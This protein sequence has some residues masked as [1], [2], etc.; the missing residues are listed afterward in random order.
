MATKKDLVEAYSFSRRRL[1]TAFVSGAPGGRE[2]EPARPGRTVVGG[3][4]LAVLLIAGAAIAGIFSPSIPE[5]WDEQ[6]GLIVSEET[7]AAYVIT[8][9]SVTEAEGQEEGTGPVL[10]PV[11]NITSAMLILGSDITPEILPQE[12]IDKET[13]GEDIG[14]L[15]APASVPSPAMLIDG[16][17]TA[18]TD[19]GDG[20]RLDL[21]TDPGVTP[22]PDGGFVVRTGADYFVVA[23]AAPD[24]ERTP[25]AYSYALPRNPAARDAML[26]ALGLPTSV[27][28]TRVSRD[29]LAL[30]PVGGPLAAASFGLEGVG[31]P[32][33]YGGG[34]SGL[35]DTARV[36][37]HVQTSA[38]AFLL[39]DE[40]PAPLDP[41]SL[42]VYQHLPDAQP[43][44]EID[45]L[46]LG[47]ARRPWL[48]ARWPETTP[49][50]VLGEQCAQLLAQAGE[51]PGVTLA[52][53]P[54]PEASSS[55]V[56]ESQVVTTV[57]PGRGAHVLS[58]GWD[59]VDQGSPFLIDAKGLAY[60]LVGVGVADLL[61]YTEHE[62][63]VVPDTW[64]EL[65][66]SGVNLSQGAAL[67]PPRPGGDG[68]S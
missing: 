49:Q 36:G 34:Q 50:P 68:C 56:R 44:L 8:A 4:A 35:P 39:T 67:C 45:Q 59:D 38:G 9:D 46:G 28:A 22:R 2:V 60:A 29:W 41:F 5:D 33:S 16:G 40:G 62:P 19:S 17:W 64:V 15:G 37:D 54:T 3:L 21:A 18:C 23:Q 14:I 12:E 7:G 30:F 13:V 25:S 11:I 31:D 32:I 58:G 61:G 27:G 42:A 26:D 65:F 63:P 66:E 6:T 57:D 24:P 55:G 1:V 53:E 20:I 10:R 43:A 52:G 48:D 51:A 47:Q